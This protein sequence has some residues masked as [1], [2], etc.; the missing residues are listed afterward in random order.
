MVLHQDGFCNKCN[1]RYTDVVQKWCKQCR[2]GN[3]KDNFTNWT[4]GND[5]I[6]NFIRETQLKIDHYD[7]LVFE[8]IPYNRLSDIKE[9]SRCGFTTAIWKDG[10]LKYDCDNM[11]YARISYNKRVALKLSHSPRNITYEFLNK[12]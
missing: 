10:P 7:D 2:V 11:K 8:W 3:L 5:I 4:S 6:N 12:V 1:E 9:I